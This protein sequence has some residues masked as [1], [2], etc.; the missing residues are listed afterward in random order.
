MRLFAEG[1]PRLESGLADGTM[2]LFSSEGRDPAVR[3][4]RF[5]KLRPIT[6]L[7]PA[8]L[9]PVAS[10]RCCRFPL[11]FRAPPSIPELRAARYLGA[12]GAF[13]EKQ[14]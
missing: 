4:Q 12:F 9:L 5:T 8:C 13:C 11:F 2:V 3:H 6:I 10:C 1:G 14:A 7:L